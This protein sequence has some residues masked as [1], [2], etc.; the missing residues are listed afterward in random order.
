MS[1]S[2]NNPDRYAPERVATEFAR[3]A[4]WFAMT[5][6]GAMIAFLCVPLV[7]SWPEPYMTAKRSAGAALVLVMPF[8]E[9]GI[10]DIIVNGTR[11]AIHTAKAGSMPLTLLG[12]AIGCLGLIFGC[13][14]SLI[15]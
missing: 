8:T 3:H 15:P 9:S 14:S 12:A 13:C 6:V 11:S 4:S 7:L 1:R 2:H 5:G 10:C